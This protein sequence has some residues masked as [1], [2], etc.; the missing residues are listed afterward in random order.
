MVPLFGALRYRDVSTLI[1]IPETSPHCSQEKR[2][3][4]SPLELS[5]A[6]GGDMGKV[7]MCLLAT[8]LE[9]SSKEQ[10]WHGGHVGTALCSTSLEFSGVFIN[11]HPNSK[12][13]G[14]NIPLFFWPADH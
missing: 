8:Q 10:S 6:G 13:S 7:L 5:G 11:T 3:K 2:G 14:N 9:R 12:Q 4:P 1:S